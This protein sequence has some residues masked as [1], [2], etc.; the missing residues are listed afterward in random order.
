MSVVCEELA[1]V[2]GVA[3]EMFD[4]YKRIQRLDGLLGG[5][6]FLPKTAVRALQA[7]DML[8]YENFKHI[9]NQV[10][11]EG[12]R[13]ARKLFSA[14]QKSGRLSGGYYNRAALESV[15]ARMQAAEA[16]LAPPK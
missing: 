3:R 10:V 7:A 6:M 8:A 5:I 12:A 9:T 11:R 16:R 14:L 15:L 4:R 13:P 1:G 2:E